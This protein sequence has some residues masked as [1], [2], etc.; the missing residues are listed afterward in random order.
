MLHES[1]TGRILCS[2]DD[3]HDARLTANFQDNPCKV[4]PECLHS[5]FY[6]S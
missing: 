3:E 5:G 2:K 6:W 4:L 1:F